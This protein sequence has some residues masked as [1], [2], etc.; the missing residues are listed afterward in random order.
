MMYEDELPEDMPVEDYDRWYELSYVDGVR[1]GP[2]YPFESGEPPTPPRKRHVSKECYDGN[3][4]ICTTEGCDCTYRGRHQLLHPYANFKSGEPSTSPR[5]Y[6]DPFPDLW[7]RGQ[8]EDPATCGSSEHGC[9]DAC[10]GEA[11]PSPAPARHGWHCNFTSVVELDA[12]VRLLSE[13][14]RDTECYCS[15]NPRGSCPVHEAEKL[16]TLND[17]LRGRL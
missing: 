17:S 14:V 3:H 2:T 4:E 7:K 11:S 6:S 12:L 16:L 10:S 9:C 13:F 8:C 15:D 5:R 1:I